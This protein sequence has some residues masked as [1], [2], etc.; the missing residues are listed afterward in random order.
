LHLL[1]LATGPNTSY[2][3]DGVL[4]ASQRVDISRR[5]NAHRVERMATQAMR[6]LDQLSKIPGAPKRVHRD[7]AE[8]AAIAR[9]KLEKL[10]KTGVDL[11]KY[12]ALYDVNRSGKISYKDFG[13]TLLAVS[14]GLSREEAYQLASQLDSNRVGSVDYTNL[15]GSLGHI[16][17]TQRQQKEA[18][19]FSSA[20]ANSAAQTSPRE[21]A[22]AESTSSKVAPRTSFSYVGASS[23]GNSNGNTA[24]A[25]SAQESAG[26]Q[27]H[28]AESAAPAMRPLSD[29]HSTTYSPPRRELDA[30]SVIARRFF[31][32]PTVNTPVYGD[33]AQLQPYQFDRS[34]REGTPQ[35][36]TKSRR[37]ASSAPGRARNSSLLDS[38][39][40]LAPTPRPAWGD[41]FGGVFRRSPTSTT[42]VS[43]D[44]AALV[45]KL[46]GN[47]F[48]RA[49]ERVARLQETI[50]TQETRTLENAVVNQI[51]G[52]VARLRHMLRKHDA[53]Q[54]GMLNT[55]EFKFA[56]KKAGV[57]LS[58]EQYEK[59]YTMSA[60]DV[61]ETSIH[62]YNRGKAVDIDAFTARLQETV[63][64]AD[65]ASAPSSVGS[66]TS[67]PSASSSVSEFSAKY[68]GKAVF[69]DAA[70]H[71]DKVRVMKKVLQ[72]A[73]KLSNPHAIYNHIEP[74]HN[75][76][77]SE[78]Q[79]QDALVYMGANLSQAEF[80]VLMKSVPKDPEGKVEIA[81][82]EK[83]LRG[84]VSEYDKSTAQQAEAQH[85]TF[86]HYSGSFRTSDDFAL[87]HQS[88]EYDPLCHRRGQA[89]ETE[90][91][92]RWGQLQDIFQRN[93]EVVR[94]AFSEPRPASPERISLRDSHAERP[95]EIP[96]EE[97]KTVSV[98]GLKEKL[99][100]S[101]LP[102][103]ADDI[104]RVERTLARKGASSEVSL[105]QFCEAVGLEVKVKDRDRLGE[106]HNC[107][108]TIFWQLNL[109]L[110]N[111]CFCL[112]EL[113]NTH[114]R[115]E[116]GGVF[117]PSLKTQHVNPS[118]S[119]SFYEG[120]TASTDKVPCTGD[121]R[122]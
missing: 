9:S 34:S 13:D 73:A 74:A 59:L 49:D 84:E 36:L 72:S 114:E 108:L 57:H 29:R 22:T 65:S 88:T 46:E 25:A 38:G 117:R 6:V 90:T 60:R 10:E 83:A 102:L 1:Y 21:A 2:A 87:S 45:A 48:Y 15:L 95:I 111:L 64:S 50:R 119:T 89:E 32:N 7:P 69:G 20:V 28:A 53:S 79:M 52:G 54:S 44:D 26:A 91:S 110:F 47:P 4:R 107:M 39:C 12:Y 55:E 96:R 61:A 75:G 76:F 81:R 85:R 99:A 113:Q 115:V 8:T 63:A 5:E 35:A 33:S 37:R 103:S 97:T 70:K 86:R 71:L 23:N 105:G 30:R 77:L 82:F 118:V 41:E 80:G 19:G 40:N 16:N 121:R 67:A 17:E 43:V 14:A 27:G 58:G 109:T 51:G 68:G 24:D 3:V 31:Y 62:G 122:K 112:P 66:S 98:S 92:R 120:S 42:E 78:H 116:D 100:K 94:A 11:R 93:P 56:L 101:G 18:T 104:L 106:W